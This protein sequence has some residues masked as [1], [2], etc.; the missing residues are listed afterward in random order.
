MSS[1]TSFK[2]K[3]R[4]VLTLSFI[5]AIFLCGNA[6]RVSADV[7]NLT[8]S[9]A[10]TNVCDT[11]CIATGGDR[12]TTSTY[13]SY[14]QLEPNGV[15]D[16]YIT[17]GANLNNVNMFNGNTGVTTCGGGDAS[18]GLLL[19]SEAGA[20]YYVPPNPSGNS[21][22][23]EMTAFQKRTVDVNP[24]HGTVTFNVADIT[25]HAGEIVVDS[26]CATVTGT[27]SAALHSSTCS[28]SC[29]VDVSWQVP[30]GG[31]A[32]SLYNDVNLYENGVLWQNESTVSGTVTS[33]ALPTGGYTFCITGYDGFHNETNHLDC[34]TVIVPGVSKTAQLSVSTGQVNLSSGA[35]TGGGT[36]SNT[37]ATSGGSFTVGSSGCS[38]I[39][40]ST[41]GFPRS[42]TVTYSCPSGSIAANTSQPFSVT[43]SNPPT[44]GGPYYAT[45]QIQTSGDTG[46]VVTP[47]SGTSAAVVSPT[48]Q[49]VTIAFNALSYAPPPPP[50]PPQPGTNVAALNPTELNG[51]FANKKCREVCDFPAFANAL[52]HW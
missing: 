26:S 28:S 3:F 11:N 52:I 5:F 1:S 24:Y 31:G 19:S 6:L 50:G 42:T 43:V 36:I 7:E 35:L 4:H 48:T 2:I 25:C 30:A 10:N 49:D 47:S 41:N 38:I 27:I 8:C 40:N 13:I 51:N 33:N 12:D 44:S 14:V 9:G 29:A 18:S 39:P 17:W 32:P 20:T 37:S 46:T 45:M 34:A 15:W 23:T 22:T 16:D 21:V